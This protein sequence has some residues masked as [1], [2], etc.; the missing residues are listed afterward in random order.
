MGLPATFDAHRISAPEWL[1]RFAFY[2][3]GDILPPDRVWEFRTIME[4]H[5]DARPGYAVLTG[6]THTDEALLSRACWR[7]SSL[8]G[9][10]I[11]QDATGTQIRRVTDRGTAIGEGSTARYA[12]SRHGGNLHTDGAE[13]PL[14]VPD[15]FALL[16][17][18]QA[19]TGGALRLVHLDDVITAMGKRP[20]L[21]AL[22]QESFRFDRR[23]D[24]PPGEPPTT[25]KPVFF[26][27][28]DRLA[29]TYLRAYI[30]SGHRHEGSPKLTDEQR[31]ALDTLDRLLDDPP[32]VTEDKLQSGE[33]AL[34]DNKRLLHGR[35][36]FVDTGEPGER[37][38][39]LRTWIRRLP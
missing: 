32:V 8:A 12:D 26:R 24:Q 14:P 34:F 17:V 25:G 23:G 21:L 4:K 3:S 15:Y 10:V 18:R 38:L 33:F 28:G 37:R 22:L 30:E 13:A 19:P 39:L 35:T 20:D 6:F 7:L 11:A 9:Q 27:D 2:D 5:V 1:V 36:T 29:V 31:E 16:C